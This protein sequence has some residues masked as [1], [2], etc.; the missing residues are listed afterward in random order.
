ML[1][2]NPYKS[3]ADVVKGKWDHSLFWRLVKISIVFL[4]FF[5]ALDVVF[6]LQYTNT[7]RVRNSEEV[8]SDTIKNFFF[9]WKDSI[10]DN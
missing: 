6:Y 9:N 10:N 7:A 5:F 4:L 1:K 2:D 3:P 8:T